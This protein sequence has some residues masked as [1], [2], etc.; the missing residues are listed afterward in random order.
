MFGIALL[1]ASLQVISVD[2][3]AG[4]HPISPEIYGLSFAPGPVLRRC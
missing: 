1:A 4:R 2:A 3:A